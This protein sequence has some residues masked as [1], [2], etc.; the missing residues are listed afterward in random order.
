[1]SFMLLS[2]ALITNTLSIME[3]MTSF[4]IFFLSNYYLHFQNKFLDNF[5]KISLLPHNFPRDE[6][7]TIL[8]FCKGQELQNDAE[9][10]G[11]TTVGG[12]EIIKKIQVCIC[13]FIVPDKFIHVKCYSGEDVHNKHI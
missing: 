12:G 11:G 5:S 3:V 9:Q 4:I 1:M 2:V 10:A 8:V 7:R 13:I 6:Q